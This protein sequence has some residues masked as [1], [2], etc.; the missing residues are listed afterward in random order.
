MQKLKHRYGFKRKKLMNT[1]Y[2]SKEDKQLTFGNQNMEWIDTINDYDS[3]KKSLEKNKLIYRGVN[4][5]K[6]KL[7]TSLQRQFLS[8]KVNRNR[9]RTLFDFMN[10]EINQ[11]KPDDVLPKYYKALGA[12][13]TD[14]LY[15]SFL[16]HYGAP[17]TL[18]DFSEDID[19]ALYFATQDVAYKMDGAVQNHISNYVSLYWIDPNEKEEGSGLISIYEKV[20]QNCINGIA[21][22]LEDST[23]E[24]D[25]FQLES[26]V[27]KYLSFSNL[28]N[29]NLGVLWGDNDSRYKRLFLSSDK[30]Y[31]ELQD[32]ICSSLR[33]ASR[34]A[35]R[36][37][38]DSIQFLF[39]QAVVIANLNQVAQ[40][41]CFIHYMPDDVNI[42]LEEFSTP[43]KRSNLRIHCINIHKSLCP[44][45]RRTLT[46][47]K[48]SLF[49]KPETISKMIYDETVC[50]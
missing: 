40:K 45:I 34:S 10:E 36:K 27:G 48:D 3:V 1:E 47:T 12:P 42:P 22:L 49:P 15:M 4:E 39:K 17:T 26:E 32:Q 7:Y 23:Y 2:N 30:Y 24:K 29:V 19:T 14:Y 46:V 13:V 11:I 5:A 31:S 41:G 6:Y 28:E 33:T 20:L 38:K 8:N 37:W 50:M 18:M 44:I 9:Y 21:H 35:A 16:Q 25:S 43:D